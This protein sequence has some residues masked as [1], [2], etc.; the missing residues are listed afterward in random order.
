[1]VTNKPVV[2]MR[3]PVR[4]VGVDFSTR[5]HFA[6]VPET[7]SLIFTIGYNVAAVTF[8]RYVG[9]A[10]CVANKNSGWFF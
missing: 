4:G 2:K 9:N 5:S 8:S 7:D 10:L 3:H 6:Q 1:M